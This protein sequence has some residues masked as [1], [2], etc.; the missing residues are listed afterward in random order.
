[1]DIEIEQPHVHAAAHGAH[2]RHWSDHAMSLSALFVS[3]VSI[4][5]AWQ[6][7]IEMKKLVQANSF[8]YLQIFSSDIG[9]NGEHRFSLTTSNQG[10][11][12][13][14]I[15]TAEVLLDGK[16]VGSA[17]DLLKAC[18]NEVSS[19]VGTSSLFGRMLRPGEVAPYLIIPEEPQNSEFL[20]RFKKAMNAGR[21][22]TRLCFCSVFDECWIAKSRGFARPETVRQCPPVERMYKA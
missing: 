19:D 17:E 22:E 13:A 20:L 2:A 16:P 14:E 21:I 6:H 9:P 11:G 1:M 8:P 12:P 10:V 4:L 7:G 15:R 3:L 5:I 18:C